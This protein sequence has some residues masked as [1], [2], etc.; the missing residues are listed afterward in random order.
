MGAS[1][2]LDERE[3]ERT[4]RPWTHQRGGTMGAEKPMKPALNAG[5]NVGRDLQDVNPVNTL[6]EYY[7]D[8]VLHILTNTG[9]K[10]DTD[11]LLVTI[12]Y[13]RTARESHVGCV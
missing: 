4:A 8:L 13:V 10:Q 9:V 3:L 2:G 7:L 11:L 12:H 5:P 6:K 1:P